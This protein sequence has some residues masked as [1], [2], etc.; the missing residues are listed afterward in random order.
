V[1]L[2][3]PSDSKA[4]YVSRL[5]IAGMAVAGASL[6]AMTAP[7]PTGPLV[8]QRDVK[9]AAGELDWSTVISDTE[10]NLADLQTEAAKGSTDLSTALG[11]VSEHFG[12][13][14][15]VALTG[16][17]S[18][19]Q[20]SLYGGWYGSDDGYV[21]GLLGG[22]VTNPATGISETNSL[23]G[24]LSADFQA[25]N[26]EQAYSDVN[27]YMLEVTDHT[28]R[29]LLSP[30]VDE[31][32]DS[33]VT[34]NSIPVELSQIQ[35]S[36]LQTFGDYN[37]LKDGLQSV[38]SPEITAQLVLTK[39]LDTISADFTA[40]DTTQ[41]M[42]DLNNLSSDVFGALINGA[43]VGTNPVDGSPQFFSGLLGDGSLLQH[44]VLTWPEQFVT[45]LGTL[46]E[47][48]TS[49]TADAVGSSVPDLFT[50]LLSF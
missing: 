36:L 5:M 18:G 3:L 33:G 43:D 13:Q 25:G 14:I 20:N 48:T 1:Q 16:F 4:T 21:F 8:Q 44:L 7:T 2:A 17:E 23:I 31:T 41:G 9:L 19:I 37:E 30:L 6:F 45:A 26:S 11:N 42:S 12:T 10:A 47:S 22:T 28:L 50:G 32:S 27:A 40:G 46:G 49:L 39:D 34:T 29:P 38:L 35:T 15:T 24:L